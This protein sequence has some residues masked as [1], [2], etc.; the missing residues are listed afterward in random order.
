MSILVLFFLH[1]FAV[2]IL[3][4][5]AREINYFSLIITLCLKEHK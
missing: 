1:V 3:P 2:I 4:C 5:S